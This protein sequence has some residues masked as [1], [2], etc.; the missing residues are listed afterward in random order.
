MTPLEFGKKIKVALD[1][2][3]ISQVDMAAELDIHR[4]TVSGWVAGKG[5]PDALQLA[6]LAELT[7]RSVAWF[8]GETAQSTPPPQLERQNKHLLEMVMELREEVYELKRR[9]WETGEYL[10]EACNG[11]RDIG[12]LL[13]E[14]IELRERYKIDPHEPES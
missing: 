7:Q 5:I 9:I 12:K 2:A 11:T 1:G 13:E 8:Y 4:N 6:K 3:A 14:V 10:K